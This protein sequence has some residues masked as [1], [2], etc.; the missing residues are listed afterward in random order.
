MHRTSFP[1]LAA[2]VLLALPVSACAQT[3]SPAELGAKLDLLHQDM[4]AI[5]RALQAGGGR[6]TVAAGPAGTGNGTSTGRWGFDGGEVLPAGSRRAEFPSPRTAAWCATALPSA[7]GLTCSTALAPSTSSG[8]VTEAV[9]NGY[10]INGVWAKGGGSDHMPVPQLLGSARQ[11]VRARRMAVPGSSTTAP[12]AACT[13]QS[14]PDAF[15]TDASGQTTSTVAAS[16]VTAPNRP[17]RQ[18]P[19]PGSSGRT[20]KVC[21]ACQSVVSRRQ[22]RLPG[23]ATRSIS[24]RAATGKRRRPGRCRSRSCSRTARRWTLPA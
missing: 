4:Q 22:S 21:G 18:S 24:G 13:M 14:L 10:T 17:A 15:R 5:L 2:A 7:V 16:N 23:P 11:G 20:L 6:G 9:P 8:P 3:N 19:A 1:A 12:V